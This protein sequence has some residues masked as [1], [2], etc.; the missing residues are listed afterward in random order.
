M[1]SLTVTKRDP[2]TSVNMLRKEGKM[3]AVFY[4]KKDAST[5]ITISSVDFMRAFRQAG[6]S[7][8]VTLVGEGI[9]ADALIH[10]VQYDP[11]RD[12]P[13]HADFYTFEKGQKV[14]VNVP[15]EFV[16]ISEAVKSLGGTLVKVLHEVE[17]EAEPANLPHEITVDISALVN[18]DSQILVKDIKLPAGV[19]LVSEPEEVVASVSEA[20][21]EPEEPVNTDI[22]TIEVEKKGKVEEEGA[23]AAAAE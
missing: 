10:D 15:V 4:G 22:S 23:E 16:G 11:V 13:I 9:K 21:K 19:T 20:M 3:P 14:K 1:I 8:V 6:E 7:T 17:V 5:P 12:T 2:N 18:L